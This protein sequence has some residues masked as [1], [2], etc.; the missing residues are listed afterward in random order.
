MDRV[1]TL[2]IDDSLGESL[3]NSPMA[4]PYLE[5]SGV[6]ID[7]LAELTKEMMEKPENGKAKGQLDF[8]GLFDRYRKGC[9]AKESRK[10]KLSDRWKGNFLQGI[11]CTD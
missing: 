11:S 5:E 4:A 8:P 6:D 2:K 1:F 3:K 10:S 7:Q 9:K